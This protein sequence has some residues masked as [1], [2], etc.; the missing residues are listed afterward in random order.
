MGGEVEEQNKKKK[1]TRAFV[2]DAGFF[3]LYFQIIFSLLSLLIFI[4]FSSA[5]LFPWSLFLSLPLDLLFLSVLLP[6]F[7]NPKRR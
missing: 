3:S 6:P 4:S 1:S 7:F 5:L 2:C